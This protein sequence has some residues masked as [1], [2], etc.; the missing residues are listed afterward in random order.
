M[1]R[2]ALTGYLTSMIWGGISGVLGEAQ[3]DPA[4][5]RVVSLAEKRT[6]EN[7]GG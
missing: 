1:S 4:R 6:G 5:L 3:A 7:G 2:A